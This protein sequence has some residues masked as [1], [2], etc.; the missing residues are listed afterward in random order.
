MM[1]TFIG[2]CSITF[3]EILRLSR[4]GCLL[5]FNVTKYV[6]GLLVNISI[7]YIGFSLIDTNLDI[8]KYELKN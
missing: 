5:V 6:Y 4:E 7:L 1:G 3:I 8:T 2:N